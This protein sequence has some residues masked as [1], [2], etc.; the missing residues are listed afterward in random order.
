MC[1]IGLR[2]ELEVRSIT[3]IQNQEQIAVDLGR[4]NC[5]SAPLS[6]SIILLALSQTPSEQLKAFDGL[7]CHCPVLTKY[8]AIDTCSTVVV[9]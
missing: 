6:V 5:R 1:E 7:F 4:I 8:I 3:Q 2:G 9:I